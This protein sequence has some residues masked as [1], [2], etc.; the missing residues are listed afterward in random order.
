MM[1]KSRE[2]ATHILA[3]LRFG[4][5]SSR[6]KE[7]ALVVDLPLRKPFSGLRKCSIVMYISISLPGT[8]NSKIGRKFVGL[9]ASLG[10]T[11]VGQT[12]IWYD[13][14]DSPAIRFY[15]TI[16]LTANVKKSFTTLQFQMYY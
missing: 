13:Y 12:A 1:L 4:R 14:R 11:G 2:A 15:Y 6:K 9:V 3:S 7:M 8:G 16:S 10:R 5:M